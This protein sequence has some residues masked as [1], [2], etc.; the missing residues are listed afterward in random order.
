MPPAAGSAR[1]F[2][3]AAEPRPEPVRA[4]RPEIWGDPEL[5]AILRRCAMGDPEGVAALRAW[6][7]GRLAAVLARL[8]GDP[9]LAA[10]H[11]E[12]V[13]AALADS[14]AEFDATRASAE[15][16]VFA[17]LRLQARNLPRR[18]TADRPP[19]PIAPAAP[20]TQSE[21]PGLAA[22]PGPS[23]VSAP[24]AAA[25]GLERTAL[26]QHRAV[27]RTI[28]GV[29]RR[30]FS[31]R[32]IAWGLLVVIVALVA[33][34]ALLQ[35]PARRTTPPGPAAGVAALTAPEPSPTLPPA[36][37]ATAPA[38]K[39]PT[40]STAAPRPSPPATTLLPHPRPA[41][42]PATAT[43]PALAGATRVFVHHFTA[44]EAGAAMAVRLAERLRSQGIEVAAIRRVPFGIPA[45]SV[46]YFYPADRDA[47]QRLVGLA[48]PLLTAGGRASPRLPGDFTHYQPKPRPGTVEVWIPSR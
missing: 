1:H 46:R 43:P 22:R 4:A 13:L 28:A 30:R 35:L 14:A 12:G 44:D 5:A 15:D 42:A 40:E 48:G 37:P 9:T 32:R 7:G 27:R 18:S 19:A 47:A 38:A 8:L 39:P 6:Q 29:R 34:L 23:P 2:R 45:A 10:R 36:G 33:A 26:P 25:G 16:W 17:Q 41:A 24:A 3:P 31:R 20:A 21:P 11:L